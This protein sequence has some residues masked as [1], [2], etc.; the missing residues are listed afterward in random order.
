MA[1]PASTPRRRL[2]LAPFNTDCVPTYAIK[3]M[4]QLRSVQPFAHVFPIR[5]M[6]RSI[7]PVLWRHP[8]IGRGFA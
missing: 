8:E 5:A 2:G 4:S 1:K 3:V 7:L 6:D